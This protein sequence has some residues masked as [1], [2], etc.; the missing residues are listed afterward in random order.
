VDG[1]LATSQIHFRIS[2]VEV[3]QELVLSFQS[4]E[5]GRAGGDLHGC[6]DQLDFVGV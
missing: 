5:G 2:S 3:G 1:L 4:N 6:K